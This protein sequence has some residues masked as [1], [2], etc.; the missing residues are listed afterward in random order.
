MAVYAYPQI[1]KDHYNAFREILPE[2][3]ETFEKWEADLQSKKAK[4]RLSHEAAGGSFAS[5]DVI[6]N[7]GVFQTY[8]K[9]KK[10]PLTI[11]M[12]YQFASEQRD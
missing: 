11:T 1:L 7:G 2:L 5:H 10:G 9:E 12:L 3:P 4:D 8:C 6:V